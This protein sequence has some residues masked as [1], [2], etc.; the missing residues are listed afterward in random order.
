M[1]LSREIIISIETDDVD[2]LRN[3]IKYVVTKT[4]VAKNCNASI[5]HA[6]HTMTNTEKG[7]LII[8][9]IDHTF[10]G[11]SQVAK[12]H[13]T[14]LFIMKMMQ[15]QTKMKSFIWR[16]YCRSIGDNPY[17][18]TFKGIIELSH[19]DQPPKKSIDK[20]LPTKDDI[21]EEYRTKYNE[22][23]EKNQVN[24]TSSFIGMLDSFS[25]MLDHK[26]I[27]EDVDT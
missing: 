13:S 18:T 9:S 3:I 21:I 27:P 11:L 2:R 7:T 1:R 19:V 4:T 5:S 14:P 15:Y 8:K 17:N 12:L 20:Q 24:I 23:T 26:E 16:R 22:L 10:E 6:F 25:T